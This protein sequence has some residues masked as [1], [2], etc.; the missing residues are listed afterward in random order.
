MSE[1]HF[2]IQ[3]EI[4]TANEKPVLFIEYNNNN[5]KKRAEFTQ[6]RNAKMK[7]TLRIDL[8]LNTVCAVH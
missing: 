7:Q 8:M 1:I 6:E 2:G 4:L 5:N 3:H